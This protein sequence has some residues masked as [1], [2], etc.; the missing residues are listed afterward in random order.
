MLYCNFCG[1][2]SVPLDSSSRVCSTECWT[3]LKE[4][5]IKDVLEADD[6]YQRRFRRDLDT[7]RKELGCLCPLCNGRHHLPAKRPGVQ[8]Q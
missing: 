3:R 1:D 4:S 8:T 5:V 6:T 2:R 7:V